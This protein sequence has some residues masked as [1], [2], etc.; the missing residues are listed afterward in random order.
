MRKRGV[1]TI[2]ICSLRHARSAPSR[3][4]SGK[5]LVDVADVVLDN[6]G[7][8]GDA[9]VR[10][11]GGLRMGPTSAVAA[12]ALLHAVLVGAANRA[13]RSGRP[14]VV[15]ESANARGKRLSEYER[16]FRGYC[17]RIRWLR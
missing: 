1:P 7:V 13:A 14:P 15:L 12:F 4:P 16:L 10:L 9:A 11:P 5:N 6:G 8:P 2:A 3:H 17:R